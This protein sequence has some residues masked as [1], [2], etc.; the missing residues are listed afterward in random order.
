V[1]PI[2]GTLLGCLAIAIAGCG[3]SSVAGNGDSAT[4]SSGDGA[5][6]ATATTPTPGRLPPIIYRPAGL[7]MSQKVPLLIAL[8]G[9]FGDPQKMEGLTHFEKV[10][11]E[12]GFV[13]AYLASSDQV[14]PW[15]P[16]SDLGYISSMIDQITASENIDPSRVYV[17]GFSAGGAET[18]R[19]GCMLSSKVAAIA[20]VSDAMSF[21]TLAACSVTKP[22]SEL[23][24]IGDKNTELYDGIPGKLPSAVQTTTNWRMLDGCSSATPES[25]Q[26]SV[27]SQQTWSSCTDG[28]AVGLYVIHGADHVWPPYGVGAPQNYPTSEEVWAF[29]SAH[30]AAPSHLS[31]SD[32]KLLSLRVSLGGRSRAVM[33]KFR[34]D[35]TVTIGVQI[36][37]VRD[38]VARKTFTHRNGA[39]VPLRL[40]LPPATKAGSYEA[41]FTIRDSYG[42]ELVI[43]RTIRVR[44]AA[45]PRTARHH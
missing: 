30:R 43:T 33:S 34:L 18:W 45:T 40:T 39:H 5:S 15:A 10:A 20:V 11:T 4:R 19:A 37:T 3:T 32:A 1:G 2:V 8:Y 36:G 21:K 24:I 35:E 12:H 38:P 23:L 27:V 44:D 9:T 14:H 25:E 7:S 16:A 42:R 29:L 6:S 28:S 17:T 26:V 41:V 31:A 13:V 22:V